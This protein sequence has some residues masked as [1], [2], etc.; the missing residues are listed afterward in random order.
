MEQ[1]DD[2]ATGFLKEQSAAEQDRRRVIDEKAR[3]VK[4]DLVRREKDPTARKYKSD[5]KETRKLRRELKR[6]QREREQGSAN[7]PWR[8][9]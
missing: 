8:A 1:Y 9:P 5:D 2:G 6:L 7:I 3:D 4:A